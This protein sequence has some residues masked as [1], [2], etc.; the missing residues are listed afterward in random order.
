MVV[1]AIIGMLA[2]LALPGYAM[3]VKRSR[4][5]ET[6][7]N[8][9]AMYTSAAAYYEQE[10]AG[11]RG[12]TAVGSGHCIVDSSAATLP[13][14]PGPEAVS[15]DF[16]TDPSFQ[17]LGFMIADPVR[18]AYGIASVGGGCGQTPDAALYT[19]YAEGDLDG[20][21]I[22]SMYEMAAGSDSSNVLY[23]SP[24]IYAVDAYE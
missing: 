23:R 14:T 7:G 17:S 3:Y 10:R 2:S 12:T 11:A 24:G 21:S 6:G 8:L 15:V 22:T 4:A 9:K 13:A 19:F 16:T 5:S 1:V 20:D 18:Y